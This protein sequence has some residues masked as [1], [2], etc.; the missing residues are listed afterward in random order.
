MT[1]VVGDYAV[2]ALIGM[3]APCDMP[4][5]FCTRRCVTVLVLL[6]ALDS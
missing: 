3:G 2:V 6:L 5:G 4:R 1:V